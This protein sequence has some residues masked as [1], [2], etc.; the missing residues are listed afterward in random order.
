M[1]SPVRDVSIRWV[2]GAARC[3]LVPRSARSIIAMRLG[4]LRTGAG[5][6]AGMPGR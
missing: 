5:Q 6:I 4:W 1:A 2:Q 3:R